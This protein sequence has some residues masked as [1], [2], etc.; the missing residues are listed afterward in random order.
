MA[1]LAR[2]NPL[3]ICSA[4]IRRCSRSSARQGFRRLLEEATKADL[5]R[6]SD[7]T[8]YSPGHTACLVIGYYL[9]NGGPSGGQSGP[10]P[11]WEAT[12]SQA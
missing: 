12:F 1:T 7:G 11:A 8:K 6:P 9:R 4:K 3:R 2:Q 10:P 5:A